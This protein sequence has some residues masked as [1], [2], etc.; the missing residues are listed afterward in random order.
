MSPQTPK[1][2]REEVR[3]TP[4]PMPPRTIPPKGEGIVPIAASALTEECKRYI[5]K[6]LGESPEANKYCFTDT[7]ATTVRYWTVTDEEKWG[8]T[9]DAVTMIVKFEGYSYED[10]INKIGKIDAAKLA[11]K[12]GGIPLTD[13]DLE[14]IRNNSNAPNKFCYTEVATPTPTVTPTPSPTPKLPPWQPVSPEECPPKERGYHCLT[15][16]S[17]PSGASIYIDGEDTYRLTPE[18]FKI[19]EGVHDIKL[20]KAGYADYETSI[21]VF[22][23]KRVKYTLTKVTPTPVPPIEIEVRKGELMGYVDIGASRI[24]RSITVGTK[25]TY[26]I[27]VENPEEG[28]AA[29]YKVTLEFI[30]TGD[31]AGKKFSFSS[32]W[33]DVVDPGDG[34]SLYVDVLMPSYA[35]ADTTATYELW[36]T[37]EGEKATVAAGV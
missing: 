3:E 36:V 32:D 37:L 14:W 5:A 26:R 24:P 13:S 10:K 7:T 4:T 21:T 11:E 27:R 1:V 30:G 34:I 28:V 17:E 23:E 33:S 15:I 18:T 20:T 19:V 9:L 8:S 12:N 29:T 6:Y 22:S 25:Y 2:P 16:E 35:L 31:V